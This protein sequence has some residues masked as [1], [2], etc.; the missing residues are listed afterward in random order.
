MAAS[1][2]SLGQLVV[3]ITMD[4]S[5]YNAGARDI[6]STASSVGTSLRQSGETGAAGMD[7]IG[8]HTAAARRELLVMAHE[9]L[10]GSFKNLIGSS[11]VLAEEMDAVEVVTSAAGL[12]IVGLIG[13]IAAFAVAAVKGH[14]E[15]EKFNNSLILTGN[16]AGVTASSFQALTQSI[17]S[18]T[19]SSVGTARE[20][21]Q[22][23]VFSGQFTGQ[24]LQILG[25]DVVRMHDLTGKSLDD[26]AEDYAKM[27]EG[28][29]KWA[30]Q[31][32]TSMHFITTA[33]YE[34]IRALEDA[35]DKQGAILAV[36]KA[37]DAQISGQ[38]LQNL[39]YLE[40]AWRGVG[41][42]I[43]GVWEWMKSLGRAETAAEKIAAATAEVQRL[44]NALNS[45]TGKMNS[46]LLTPQLN[47]ARAQLDALN[48]DA[49]KEQDAA[50]T[51]SQNDMEQAAGIKASDFL[52]K[53]QD[54]ERGIHR[55]DDALSE[56]RKNVAAYNKA[57]PNNQ[58][59]A[60][61]QATDEAYLRKH[62][63][64]QGGVSAANKA[65]K[66][67][68]AAALQ[69][70][71]NGL[72]LISA[73]Y[74][75]SDDQLQALHKATLISDQAYYE[76]EI[77]LADDTAQQQIAAYQQQKK[78]LQDAYWRAPSEE[79]IKI[80]QQIGEVDTSITKVTQENAAK[81]AVLITQQ[82]EAQ[83]QYKKSIEDAH[84][85]LLAQAGVSE[86]KAL[87]DFDEKYRGA[88]LQAVSTGDLS[89]AAFLDQ[90]RQLTALSARYNDIVAQA[91]A[92]QMK[93]DLDQQTGLA[94]L[95]DGFSQ[96]RD[97]SEETVQSLQTLYDQ[98]NRLSWSTNDEGVLRSLDQLRDKIRQSMVDSQGYLQDFTDAGR[99][100][101][102]GLFSDI[103]TGT[104]TP[105]QAVASMVSSMLAS[106][107][108]IFANKAY[109]SLAN[110]ILG[111]L[112][113]ST[114]TGSAGYNFTMPASISGSGALFGVGA[115]LGFATGGSVWG[116][117]SGTSDSINARLSNGEFVVKES[118]ASR[119]GMR[120]FLTALNGGGALS[121]SNRFADGGSVEGD[122]AS[123]SSPQVEVNIHNAPAG[124]QTTQSKTASGGLRL[125]VLL[126]AIDQ[127]IA[128]GI[129][130]GRGT[131]AKAMQR[132]YGLNRTVGGTS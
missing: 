107:A 1:S 116:A 103:V 78:T 81:V 59:S 52:K 99:S 88:S 126:P 127:H 57:N 39:G 27:P 129:Q 89:G 26:I 73:A 104:K 118:V 122:S 130:S 25:A 56:Y 100:A 12:S 2:G 9:T 93:I 87:A 23:L 74:K 85:A 50:T 92:A 77:S 83:R 45:A 121:G 97:N 90:D 108:Q 33:Q 62:Y 86:T 113:P 20:G 35:G 125:D 94:G 14:A 128:A 31:H 51:K 7:K 119:P 64:D 117:G 112:S 49:L 4:P 30:E 110:S 32:N 43:G 63:A 42:A 36:A 70:T 75:A 19:G 115:G 13:T 41:A 46:D 111:F 106:F 76:A 105:A 60:A 109:S 58:I 131:T 124:T 80:T 3:Q 11:M 53:L 120:G 6:K 71:K 68:L 44:Q 29:A 123:A 47:A 79:R 67:E 24:A 16:F 96:L 28:V 21:L 102:T 8:I 22:A 10:T 17:A 61:Q 55:V 34:Y 66:D 65:R 114:L 18:S 48:R 69:T 98:V 37:L 40:K 84:N 15:T 101:F 54:E 82:T 91:K 38:S 132:Q 95:F 72:D 5:A